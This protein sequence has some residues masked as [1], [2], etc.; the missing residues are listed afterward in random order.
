MCEWEQISFI[1]ETKNAFEISTFTR[2][3]SN[4]WQENRMI[5]SPTNRAK[6][7]SD[8]NTA[9]VQYGLA[10]S[11]FPFFGLFFMHRVVTL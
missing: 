1:L 6:C 10:F 5:E 8:Q 11:A 3:I 2:E 9:Q 4:D 7:I